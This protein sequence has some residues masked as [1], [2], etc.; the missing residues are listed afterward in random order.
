MVSCSG[1]AFGIVNSKGHA[2]HSYNLKML[3]VDREI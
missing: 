3:T 2:V 1:G